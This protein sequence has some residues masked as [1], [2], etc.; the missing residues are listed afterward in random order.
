MLNFPMARAH[1][2]QLGREQER[3]EDERGHGQHAAEAPAK[4]GV[5]GLAHQ[6]EVLRGWASLALADCGFPE[7]SS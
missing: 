1:L 2:L 4:T 5:E 3:G 7:G 6:R